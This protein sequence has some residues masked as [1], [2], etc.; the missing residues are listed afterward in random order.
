MS[1]W[2][3]KHCPSIYLDAN[4]ITIKYPTESNGDTGVING[5]TYTAVNEATLR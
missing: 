2:I 5:K 4:G 1:V 3:P